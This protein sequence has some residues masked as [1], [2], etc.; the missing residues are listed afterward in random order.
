MTIFE[1]LDVFYLNGAVLFFFAIS[2]L[3]KTKKKM[4][5]NLS[6]EPSGIFLVQI[7]FLKKIKSH[8][9]NVMCNERLEKNNTKMKKTTTYCV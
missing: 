9:I 6:N 5:M 2:T 4:P 8:Q 1:I 3:F 7:H